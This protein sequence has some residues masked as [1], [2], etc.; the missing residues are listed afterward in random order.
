MSKSRCGVIATVEAG[1][2]VRLEPDPNHPN[3]GFCV[4]GESV[5]QIVYDPLRL[6]YP[7]RRT[8]PKS[9]D[10]PGLSGAVCSALI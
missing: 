2:F 10:D 7:M 9:E 8:R 6:K 4:N 1:Q 5:P 3:R